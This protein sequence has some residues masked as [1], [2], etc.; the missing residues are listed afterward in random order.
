MHTSTRTRALLG[1]VV[2]AVATVA[3]WWAWLGWDTQY[4]VDPETSSTS[5][6]YEGW[7]VVGCVLS[8]MALAAV[9]GWLF[10]PW[11]VVPVMTVSFT[12]AWAWRAA[13]SDDSGLWVIG[14]VGM[15]VGLA[16]GST[17]V[18]AGVRLFRRRREASLTSPRDASR[19]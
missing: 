3:L 16:S 6:P 2:L 4:T 11:L 13:T 15:L 9:G 12:A 18:S 17:A 19:R 8:L 10:S 7:Q 5:G 14:A 1:G